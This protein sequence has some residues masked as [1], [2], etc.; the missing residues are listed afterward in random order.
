MGIYGGT[1]DPVHRGHIDPVLAAVGQ[2]GLAEAIYLPTAR[3]PHKAGRPLAPARRRYEMVELAVAGEAHLRVSGFELRE[4]GPAYT[5]ET[6]EHFR[7]ADPKVDLHLLLGTDSFLELHIFRRWR[8]IVS[9]VTFAVLGRSAAPLEPSPGSAAWVARTQ[10]RVVE[11][12]HPPVDVSSTEVRRYLS[13]GDRPPTGWVP[14][15]VVDY[16]LKH[17]LYS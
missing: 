14:E 3:P 8:D 6:I 5:I 13:R 15:A 17:Q 11:I 9:A 16:A 4:D 7:G 12:D 2:L 1:F 10:G